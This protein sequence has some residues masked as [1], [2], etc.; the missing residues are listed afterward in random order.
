MTQPAFERLGPESP[1]SPVVM[2]VPHAGRNYSSELQNLLAVPLGALT[3]LEDRHLD[4]VAIP[5]RGLRTMLLQRVP[6]A[7]IDLNRDEAERDPRVDA[8]AV[9][10]RRSEQSMKLRSGLGLVPRRAGQTADIWRRR[11]TDA[12][13]RKR[14]A[15]VHRPYHVE[16]GRLLAAARERWGIAVLLDLHSMPPLLPA[17]PQVVLGDRYGRACGARFVARTERICAQAGLR[18]AINAP[19]AGAHILNRHGNPSRGVHALQVELD[20]KLYLDSAL[21]QP[22]AGVAKAIILVRAIADALADEALSGRLAAAA[23]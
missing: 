13:I 20:R 4:A 21:D 6:R 22:G 19:Y 10:G 15:E 3:V 9:P 8:G 12:E 14:I 17:G 11:F 1:D 2:S 18:A 5:A 7:W 23:E 16:L